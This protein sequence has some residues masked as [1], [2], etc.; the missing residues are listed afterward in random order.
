MIP[1]QPQ[2]IFIR[3]GKVD[4]GEGEIPPPTANLLPLDAE[5]GGILRH[6]LKTLIPDPDSVLWICS[7]LPRSWQ[8]GLILGARSPRQISDFNEQDFGDWHGRSHNQIAESNP[9]ASKNFW[10]D[11][12]TA[13]PPNGESFAA[14]VQRVQNRIIFINKHYSGYKTVIMI[15]HSGTIKAAY[16]LSQGLPTDRLLMDL[17]RHRDHWS[18]TQ[19]NFASSRG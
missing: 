5:Q 14:M 17:S 19:L 15:G 7:T 11:P 6:R 12:I 3:H 4:I 2:W 9:V 13:A 18:M 8:S 16:G 10:R 1:Q